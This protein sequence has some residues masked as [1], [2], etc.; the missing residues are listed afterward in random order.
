M[1][2]RRRSAFAALVAVAT[3]IAACSSQPAPKVVER[4]KKE[5]PLADPIEPTLWREVMGELKGRKFEA[6][7]ARIEGLVSAYEKDRVAGERPL[8]N[9][10]WMFDLSDPSLET[11]FE[12]WV[13]ADPDSYPARLGRGRYLGQQSA[14]RRGQRW[15]S[16]T[17]TEQFKAAEDA[18]VM[19]RADLLKALSIHPGLMPAYCELISSEMGHDSAIARKYF[20]E[21][22]AADPESL[23]LRL[24]YLYSLQPKWGGSLAQIERVVDE[25]QTHAD[26]NP[27]LKALLGFSAWVRGVEARDSGDYQGAAIFHAEALSKGE[28]DQWLR[29]RADLNIDLGRYGPA[30]QDLDKILAHNPNAPRALSSRGYAYWFD[31][32]KERAFRDLD[33]AVEIDANDDTLWRRGHVRCLAKDFEGALADY[34][35]DLKM[36]PNNS[37]VETESAGILVNVKKDYAEAERR[38]DEVLDRDPDQILAWYFH[39]KVLYLR[40]DPK[41]VDSLKHFLKIGT[42][43][44]GA[45]RRDWCRKVI[46]LPASD[47]FKKDLGPIPD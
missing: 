47:L 21:G 15:A 28:V 45:E 39:G 40:K 11:I 26:K 3:M 2:D 20:D 8:F 44:Y 38:L 33:L 31:G 7:D 46:E 23:E 42:P 24:I 13:L 29:S 17:S 19:A 16:K 5:L 35:R 37:F 41:A 22:I 10:M 30:I 32:N 12:D 25:A 43:H 36:T 9:V 6:L 18:D 1:G 34:E 27:A 14:T 4:K